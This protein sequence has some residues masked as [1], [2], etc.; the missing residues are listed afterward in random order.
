MKKVLVTRA[1]PEM[2]LGVLENVVKNVANIE[3][4]HSYMP[5]SREDLLKEVR[6]T[7]GL[8][9]NPQNIIDSEI[10]NA[11]EKLEVISIIGVGYENI[12]IEAASNK[13]IPVA[14][15]PVLQKTVAEL[16]F[17][18]ILAAARGI[19]SADSYVRSGEWKEPI[20]VIEMGTDLSG[21]TLGIVGL[22]RIGTEVAKRAKCFE[23]N[24]IYYDSE[25]DSKKEEALGVRYV[26]LDELLSSSDFVSLHTPLTAQTKYMIG[27]NEFEKMKPTAYLINTS[28]GQVIDKKALYEALV[29]NKI[30]GAALDVYEKEPVPVDDPLLKLKN[31][32]F[33][34]HLGSATIET[35]MNMFLTAVQNLGQALG[36]E[37]PKYLVNP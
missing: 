6:D 5:E 4:E 17:A 32:V 16:T 35:R 18:L 24:V 12:D 21:K 19:I 9:V 36:D 34:S 22:G 1:V 30:K 14:F 11:A 27:A 29:N 3:I 20:P 13:G 7:H 26:S 2:A 31:M 15:T 37:K 33:T 23:M 28:R 10:I 8:L 25:R